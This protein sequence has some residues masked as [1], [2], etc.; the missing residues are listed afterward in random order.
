MAGKSKQLDY[1]NHILHYQIDGDYYDFF[2][3]DKLMLQ[4]IRRRYQEFFHLHQVNNYDKILEI[5]SGGGFSTDT[6]K[7]KSP[8]FFPLDIPLG[9]LKRIKQQV[10]FPVYPSSAD[11]YELPFKE[12]TF[13]LVIMAE[14]LEHLSEPQ[15]ALKEILRILKS[16]GTL[17]ISVPYKEKISYQICIHCNKPTPTHSH[18]HSFDEKKLIE[19]VSQ[20]GFKP[21]KLSKNCN[22]IPNRLHLNYFLRNLPFRC[23]KLMDHFFNFLIDK[24]IS[25][26]LVSQKIP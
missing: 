14:V 2:S 20:A 7:V 1:S 24:P 19:L 3:P 13:H 9:N 22:K 26:I 12:N 21:V 15:K 10:S 18:L 23:W 4:E 5:G 6:L 25:L 11:V 16:G 17:I 8:L